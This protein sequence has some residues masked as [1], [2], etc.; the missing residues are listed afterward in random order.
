MN[1]NQISNPKVEVPTGMKLNDKDYITCLVSTLKELAKNYAMAMTEASCE[2][3]YSVYKEAFLSISE[4]QRE[5]YEVM[6]RK[7]WYILEAS[8]VSKIDSKCQTLT[9]EYQDLNA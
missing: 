6:F 3:L 5:V 9:Q 2:A 4:L 8:D 7:G 1:S